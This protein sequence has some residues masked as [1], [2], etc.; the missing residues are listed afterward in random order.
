MQEHGNIFPS[1]NTGGLV[2]Q[3]KNRRFAEITVVGYIHHTHAVVIAAALHHPKLGAILHGHHALGN[4]WNLD[5]RCELICLLG[6]ENVIIRTS[7]WKQHH[8]I[9]SAVMSFAG[10]DLQAIFVQDCAWIDTPFVVQHHR[11][12]VAVMNAILIARPMNE[13][14]LLGARVQWKNHSRKHPLNNEIQGN[15]ACIVTARRAIPGAQYVS[16]NDVLILHRFDNSCQLTSIVIFVILKQGICL[17]LEEWSWMVDGA[18][19]IGMCLADHALTVLCQSVDPPLSHRA[20]DEAPKN[21]AFVQLEVM[22]L[23]SKSALVQSGEQSPE[24]R[25]PRTF[26]RIVLLNQVLNTFLAQ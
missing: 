16:I 26:A 11:W 14:V 13:A 3:K 12:I 1:N 10:A 2:L 6:I 25:W 7:W 9:L 17:F 15:S 20:L 5:A 21:F 22:A 18:T 24:E 4:S 19:M 8:P 23:S